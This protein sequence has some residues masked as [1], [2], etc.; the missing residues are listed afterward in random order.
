MVP[1]FNVRRLPDRFLVLLLIAG[2]DCGRSGEQARGHRIDLLGTP[3]GELVAETRRIDFGPLEPASTTLLGE[4]WSFREEGRWHGETMDWVWAAA[5][6]VSLRFYRFRRGPITMRLRLMAAP[7]ARAG[8]IRPL[9]N[10]EALSEIELRSEWSEHDVLIPERL[11]RAGRNELELDLAGI[12]PVTSRRLRVAF[13]RIDFL[14]GAEAGAAE[15]P[16]FGADLD[17]PR[18]PPLSALKYTVR[19]PEDATLH[20]RYEVGPSSGACPPLL[21]FL[22][23]GTEPDSR[24][25]L[26]REAPKGERS[27]LEEKIP[28][29]TV[30]GR[31][32]DI[33]VANSSCPSS[34]AVV[35]MRTVAIEAPAR[36]EAKDERPRNIVVV[37]L[38][39]LRAESLRSFG[40]ARDTSPN[41]DRLADESAVFE[42]AFAQ[43]SFTAA[44]LPSILSGLYPNQHGAHLGARLAE[45]IVTLPEL[46]GARGYR[47]IAFSANPFFS[48]E[49]G[50]AQGFVEFHPL[51]ETAPLVRLGVDGAVLAEDFLPEVA[52][53]LGQMRSEPFFLFLHFIQPHEPY[54]PP[55]P[56]LG[57]YGEPGG[58]PSQVGERLRALL[59][60]KAAPLSEE[61]R[62]YVV[63]RYDENIRYADR[64][65]G[66]LLGLLLRLGYEE[67]TA[68]VL[69]ADHGEGLFEHGEATHGG[70]LYEELVHVPLIVR[71]PGVPARRIA[72]L[73]QSVDIA[74]TLL[75]IAGE[76]P[77]LGSGQ[78]L[79]P[80]MQ[81]KSESERTSVFA[82]LTSGTAMIR[83]Y[84]HKLIRNSSGR[85]ELYD[86]IEDP[87][88]RTNLASKNPDLVEGLAVRLE[89]WL[90]TG[91]PAVISTSRP[92]LDD[93]ALERLRRLGY[94]GVR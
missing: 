38:D 30:G 94:V 65:V 31:I 73:V 77:A 33:L 69:T 29:E 14:S 27:S 32:V 9:L 11:V 21:G 75:D 74:S 90:R 70:H 52:R 48:P 24:I 26:A 56:F 81:G 39:A 89:D 40:Y 72:A 58:S 46:L 34:G 87:D 82:S 91:G 15:P 42:A 5:P 68:V 18:V 51:Y 25:A 3:G 12:E 78:S 6:R 41:I 20:V 71:V 13:D 66:R 80:L 54:V 86:L 57:H 55:P 63:A 4:G 7:G 62:Q 36:P 84:R 17:S 79:L 44:S 1:D 85:W 93:K 60:K 43:S 83:T 50:T 2:A 67:N 22:T 45:E 35:E 76:A 28:L 23:D 47:T 37:L 10:G 64:Q 61:E 19:V 59:K 8:A 88:E 16:A 92:Q 53:V 49:F